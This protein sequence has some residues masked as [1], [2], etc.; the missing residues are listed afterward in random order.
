MSCSLNQSQKVHNPAIKSK[1]ELLNQALDFISFGV[2]CSC[3]AL[4][5]QQHFFNTLLK[6]EKIEIATLDTLKN[7]KAIYAAI[8]T[9][10]NSNILNVKNNSIQM[11]EFGLAVSKYVGVLNTLFIGYNDLITK[12]SELPTERIDDYFQFINCTMIAKSAIQYGEEWVD[13]ILET[14]L[15]KHLIR[16]TICDLG[17]GMCTRLIKL[18]ELTGLKG[19]GIENE[20]NVVEC[21]KKIVADTNAFINVEEGDITNLS[22]TWEDVTTVMQNF[23]FHDFLPDIHCIKILNSYLKHFPNLQYF[24][25]VDIVSPS[26]FNVPIFPGFDFI[27]GLMGK[28][29][30]SYKKTIDM[31]HDSKYKILKEVKIEGLPNTYL[32]I[33]SPE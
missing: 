8:L 25:Y 13:P 11:T 4:I 1:T 3:L 17:C 19:L 14:E 21:A 31:F 29:P 16:G 27:H 7:S 12:Q 10:S 6:N 24:Y 28:A 26:S 20:Q 32:W 15:N 30:R 5:S 18:C 22:G 2:S 33:L 9:L 23:V